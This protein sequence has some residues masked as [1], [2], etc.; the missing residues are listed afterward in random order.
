[1]NRRAFVTGLGAVLAAPLGAKA[2]QVGRTYRIGWLSSGSTP[3]VDLQSGF[4]DALR[5]MGYHEGRNL[6]IKAHYAAGDAERLRTYAQELMTLAPDAIVTF[7]TP[8]S[9]AAKQ[10]TASV[11]II[12]L[13]VGDPVG[14]GLIRTLGKPGGNVT[15]VSTA[16][17]EPRAEVRGPVEAAQARHLAHRIPRQRREPGERADRVPRGASGDEHGRRR[18]RVFLCDETGRGAGRATS[19]C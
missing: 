10:V 13:S 7:G 8:A 6:V 2:Q 1:M 14:S 5:E 12:M 16:F 18:S 9:L 19:D 15:G 4:V 3:T 11:P 17:G